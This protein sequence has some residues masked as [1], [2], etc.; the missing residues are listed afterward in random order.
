M[1]SRFPFFRSDASPEAPDQRVRFAIL[2]ALAVLTA[3]FAL[4]PFVLANLGYDLS[5]YPWNFSPILP[6]ALYAAATLRSR[7][8]ALALPVMIW[9]LAS[10]ALWLYTGDPAMGFPK[11]ILWVFAGLALSACLGLPLR[12][13][14]RWWVVGGAG[15]GAGVTFFLVSNLGVWFLSGQYAM[16][17]AGLFECYWVALPF[18]RGTLLSLAV[19]LPA[20]FVPA[21]L[22]LPASSPST[23]KTVNG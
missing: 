23:A 21:T 6:L 10:A 7:V 20:L 4:L 3:G 11:V 18:F 9:A 17:W 2:S 5:H 15:L 8:A 13:N 22:W 19:F 16:S 12:Q 14:R 1:N